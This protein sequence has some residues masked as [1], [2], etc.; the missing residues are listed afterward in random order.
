MHKARSLANAYYYNKGYYLMNESDKFKIYLP[1]DDALQIISEEEWE[2]LK[3]YE[4]Q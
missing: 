4:Q 1:K 2:M 3:Y